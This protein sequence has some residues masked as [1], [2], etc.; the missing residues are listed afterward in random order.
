M[1]KQ[2]QTKGCPSTGD[3]G[4]MVEV[5]ALVL[6]R[7][8]AKKMSMAERAYSLAIT[9]YSDEAAVMIRDIVQRL[10][11][12]NGRLTKQNRK[13]RKLVAFA[14]R[15]HLIRKDNDRRAKKI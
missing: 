13:L 14:K 1:N 9:G 3:E 7:P 5:G 6:C 8:C 4:E 15:T 2:C 10:E 12:E 11:D